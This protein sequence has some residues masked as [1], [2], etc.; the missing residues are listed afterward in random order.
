MSWGVGKEKALLRRVGP[1]HEALCRLNAVA[2]KNHRFEPT[3][4]DHESD[5]S[6]ILVATPTICV[7]N[8]SAIESRM[9]LDFLN[10]LVE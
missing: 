1:E 10:E 3:V 9:V 7:E 8:N 4:S 5:I 2:R 6:Q